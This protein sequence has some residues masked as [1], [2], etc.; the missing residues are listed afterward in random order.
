MAA[1]LVLGAAGSGSLT[2]LTTTSGYPR[3]LPALLGLGLGMGLLTAAA[4]AAATA[5]VP[6]AQSG[7][8]G[9][10]NNAARQTGTAIGVAVCGALTGGT[11]HPAH[12]VD[13]LHV[14]GIAGATLWAAAL[15]ITVT[16]IR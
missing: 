5:A 7:L 3:L 10:I 12:F 2:L 14:T 8:A 15:V 6:P 13:G 16:T 11:Q 9:G 1:G 4:V